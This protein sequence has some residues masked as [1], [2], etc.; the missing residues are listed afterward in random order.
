MFSLQYGTQFWLHSSAKCSI[1]T[2][3]FPSMQRWKSERRDNSATTTPTSRNQFLKCSE[4][5]IPTSNLP[6]FWTLHRNWWAWWMQWCHC[7]ITNHNIVTINNVVHVSLHRSVCT[8]LIFVNQLNESMILQNPRI[9]SFTVFT[10]GLCNWYDHSFLIYNV[11]LLLLPSS[12][13]RSLSYLL[14]AL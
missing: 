3:S 11:L 8:N 13:S 4:F 9:F 10:F 7:L 1:L 12:L 2:I 6:L 5:K 14:P